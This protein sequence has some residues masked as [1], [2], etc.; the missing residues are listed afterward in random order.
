MPRC[1]TLVDRGVAISLVIAALAAT[2][3]IIDAAETTSAAE[4]ATSTETSARQFH[5][6]IYAFGDFVSYRISAQIMRNLCF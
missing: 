2:T 4:D 6:G 3:P 1:Q 5:S